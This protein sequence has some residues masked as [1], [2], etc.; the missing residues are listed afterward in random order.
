MYIIF[1][2][3]RL[4]KTSLAVTVYNASVSHPIMVEQTQ[5]EPS[6]VHIHA[7]H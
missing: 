2:F 3:A 7:A 1:R 6:L 4:G 5:C